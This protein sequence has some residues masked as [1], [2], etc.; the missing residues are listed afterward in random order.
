MS[1]LKNFSILL[2]LFLTSCAHRPAPFSPRTAIESINLL[3]A[4]VKTVRGTAWVSVQTPEGKVAFPANVAID[5]S[6]V[7]KPMLRLE[8]V[9]L[10]GTTHAMMIL[11]QGGQFFWIDFD[12]RSYFEVRDTWR[13]LPVKDFPS[14]LIGLMHLPKDGRVSSADELSFIV[15]PTGSKSLQPFLVE[16]AWVDPGP[17]LYPKRVES[18]SVGFEVSFSQYQDTKD[19]YLPRKVALAGK[20]VNIDLDWRT[21]VWNEPVDAKIFSTKQMEAVVKRFRRLSK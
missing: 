11:D 5:R 12:R 2:I 19:F 16:M 3:S 21:Q 10:V 1:L 20:G 8:A 15:S 18:R 6:D 17:R 7:E 13:G 14:L 9:D 4:R